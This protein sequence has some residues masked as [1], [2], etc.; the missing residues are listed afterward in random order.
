[1]DRNDTSSFIQILNGHRTIIINR[2]SPFILHIVS[3]MKMILF[4]SV[5]VL[6]MKT[7]NMLTF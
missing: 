7:M 4:T 2:H 1:M 3:E 5:S 6:N